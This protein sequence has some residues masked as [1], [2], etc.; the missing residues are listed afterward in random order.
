MQILF[1]TG[2]RKS[3]TTLLHKLFD[4]HPE[5]NSYPVDIGLLYAYIPC[6]AG[7]LNEND[8]R[9]R[10]NAVI[11]KSTTYILGKRVSQARLEFDLEV[12]LS[13]FWHVGK[14]KDLTNASAIVQALA[15]S[16][17]EYAQLD[18]TLPFVVKET[19]QTIHART[20]LADG[21]QAKFI[22]IVRDPRDNYAAIKSGVAN[23]Y[24]KMGESEL[25]ALASVVN[26]ARMDLMIAARLKAESCSWFTS[27]RFED[28]VS[29]SNST[30]T[31][32]AEFC[33]ISFH[34][35]LTQPTILGQAFDGNSHEGERHSGISNKNSGRWSERISEFEVGVIEFWL[36]DVMRSWGYPLSLDSERAE[37]A[38]SQFYNWYNC[39]YFYRDS[40]AINRVSPA[41]T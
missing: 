33:D 31:Q 2:H 1:L 25:E 4:G 39:R 19:S 7:K 13:H 36:S 17:C 27:L 28:L 21:L 16:W 11:R 23:Y 9:E 41:S 24:S 22:H 20:M 40:V 26:R 18:P 3:G 10:I 12:F 5:I 6:H 8:A 30:M 14:S 34:T 38:Y 15:E 35:C 29:D 32:L 37:A